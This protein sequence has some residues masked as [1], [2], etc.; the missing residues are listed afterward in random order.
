MQRKVW[1][2]VGRTGSLLAAVL[3]FILAMAGG[4]S[5]GTYTVKQ[6]N[7]ATG[8]HDFQYWSD[9]GG[10]YPINDCPGGQRVQV[11]TY[12][13]QTYSNFNRGQW[14]ATAPYG[15]AFTRFQ[16]EFD[17]WNTG[18][19]Y[20][21]LEWG[22]ACLSGTNC[23]TDTWM[24]GLPATWGNP[25]HIRQ[26]SASGNTAYQIGFAL[27]CSWTATC[28][29]GA[30]GDR[31][32]AGAHFEFELLDNSGPWIYDGG[33]LFSS[34]WKRLG[35]DAAFNAYD[36]GGGVDRVELERAG[37]GTIGSASIT[38]AR[39][40]GY[41][42]RLQPCPT[43]NYDGSGAASGAVQI[44]TRNVPDGT[45]TMRLA[46]VDVAGNRS[47]GA[48]H[49][50]K[51][52]N[53]P[54]AAPQLVTVEGGET[55]RRTNQFDVD[56]QNPAGQHAAIARAHYEICPPPGEGDCTVASKAGQNISGLDG[57]QV[58]GVGEHRLK[59]WLEDEA[60]NVSQALA[61]PV[62]HLRYDSEP[63][64]VAIG[65][66]DPNDP[67]QVSALVNDRHSGLD[68]GTIEMRAPSGGW[69]PLATQA[70]GDRLVAEVDDEQ[71]PE[72]DYSFRA[73]AYDRAGNLGSS[74]ASGR[75]GANATRRFPLRIKLRI[76]GGI[77][78]RLKGRKRRKGGRREAPRVQLVRAARVRLGR[79]VV[80][81]GVLES[82]GGIPLQN[83][84]VVV[85]EQPR[86]GGGLRSIASGRTDPLGRY[87][88]VLRA[89]RS[90]TLRVRYLGTRTLRPAHLDSA[91][92]VPAPVRLRVSRGR[93]EVGEAVQFNGRLRGSSP[94]GKLI[95]MQ[96]RVRG[97]WRTFANT[98][99]NRAGRFSYS[100]RFQVTRGLQRYSFRALAPA[101][102]GYPYARGASRSVTVSVRGF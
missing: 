49:E 86:T 58:P 10:F 81:A 72:G 77:E 32:L 69:E 19:T 51:V 92:Q 6:C 22:F 55:W 5:A 53:T 83:V 2:R 74:D 18:Q 102:A 13:S 99:T 61:S 64:V 88:I 75:P 54:P 67:Q 38:C 47:A 62:A 14:T 36:I 71:L 43:G 29:T 48:W 85:F 35:Q 34:G 82:E 37:A 89:R 59:I 30:N 78:R 39:G 45:H 11:R 68:R 8:S 21:I 100:Y 23:T 44:D 12:P 40:P 1:G 50:V 42:T 90:G 80:L 3:A 27:L 101:Q 66:P 25:H 57:L 28:S 33:S 94:A 24:F 95:A 9:H 79:Q 4:A 65:A 31:R 20:N 7:G 56:W 93:V 96:A 97:Q 41:Y 52:D 60:G 84:E 98:R 15:T 46:P 73:L 70:V 91:L 87:R 17:A 63:P 26:W 16:G 76:S